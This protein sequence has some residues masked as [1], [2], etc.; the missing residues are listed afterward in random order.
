MPGPSHADLEAGNP[1]GGG[2]VSFPS[3]ETRRLLLR[4][5]VIEDAATTQRLFPKW[6]IVRFMNGIVPWP[7]P[8]D[9]AESFYREVA[10]PA[11]A[12]GTQWTWSLRLK[13]AP[14]EMIGAISLRRGDSDN[15]GFW[16][17]LPWHRQ[18]LMTEAS[19]LVTDYWFDVLGEPMLR[20]PKAA[21]NL[22]SRR[23]SKRCGMR[24]IATEQR[25]FVSGEHL[26]E[27]W[28]IT[29]EEWR[30]YRRQTP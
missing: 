17:G 28:E 1:H 3:L 7:Y 8:D 11:M 2:A 16:L 27:I 9:G 24:L 18:G 23:I 4:P 21:A 29:A 5:L 15:R 13:L 14:D 20:V 26:G 10:L 30:R 22:A 12:A 6:E 25:R 19:D